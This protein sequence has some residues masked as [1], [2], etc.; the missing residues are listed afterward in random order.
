MS[1][2]AKPIKKKKNFSG[3]SLVG[4]WLGLHA[5]TTFNPWSRNQD[6]KNH[7]NKTSGYLQYFQTKTNNLFFYLPKIHSEQQKSSGFFIYCR[8]ELQNL[9]ADLQVIRTFDVAAVMKSLRYV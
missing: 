3:N 9:R 7:K 4:Q 2:L 8:L 1:F 6:S 5:F